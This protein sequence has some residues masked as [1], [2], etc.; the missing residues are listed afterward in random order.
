MNSE[1]QHL[2]DFVDR[3]HV[4]FFFVYEEFFHLNVHLLDF[5]HLWPFRG[6]LNF[7]TSLAHNMMDCLTEV[8]Q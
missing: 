5:N 8:H 2:V 1:L 6:L 4:M 7:M 3:S